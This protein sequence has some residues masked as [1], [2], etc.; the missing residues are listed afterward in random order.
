[1]RVLRLLPIV[2]IAALVAPPLQAQQAGR[3]KDDQ[4]TI[5]G[6]VI[7]GEHKTT[8]PRSLLVWSKGDVYLDAASTAFTPGERAVGTSGKGPVFYWIDDEDDMAKHVGKRVEIVGEL[9][10]D[11][12]HGELEIDH[13]DNFTEIE[14]EW[15]GKDVKARVPTAW[16]GAGPDAKDTDFNISIRRVDVEKVNVLS[17]SCS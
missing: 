17:G 14:F 7:R 6:C 10:D 12:E 4:I 16:L 3:D 8:A 11:T 2:A 1:M 13:K 15:D 9:D 5:T